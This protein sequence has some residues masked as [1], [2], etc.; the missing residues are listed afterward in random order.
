M[1][2]SLKY[3]CVLVHVYAHA[4]MNAHVCMDIHAYM[5][6]IVNEKVFLILFWIVH[7]IMMYIEMHFILCVGFVYL[8]D[9]CISIGFMWNF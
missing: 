9:S 4:C 5:H 3:I 6:G 7:Y 8:M 2:L 1:N